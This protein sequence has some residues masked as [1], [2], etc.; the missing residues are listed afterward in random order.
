MQQTGP[1]V[2]G[3][4]GFLTTTSRRVPR[5]LREG[6]ARKVIDQKDDAGGEV[7]VSRAR[8]LGKLTLAPTGLLLAIAAVLLA[9]HLVGGR[10]NAATARAAKSV[11]IATK[12]FQMS[13]ADQKERLT[14]GC[15][16]RSAPLGGGMTT[17][18]PPGADGEGVYPHSYERLGVQRGWH[19]TAVLFDPNPRSTQA[20]DVTLQAVCGPKL[21]HVTPPH[22]TKYVKP[23]QTKKVV[24][25]CPGRRHLFAGGFQRTDFITM[26]GNYVI[27]SQAVSGKSWRVVGHAFG[28]FGG[29]LTAIAYCV[30]SKRPLVTE[31]TAGTTLGTG[32]LGT[33]TTPPCPPGRRMTSGGFSGNGSESVLFTNGMVNPDGTWSASGYGT[34]ASTSFT[35]HGYCLKL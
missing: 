11:T 19:V 1:R 5:R 35:A 4:R 13:R 14:V 7:V 25:T 2:S 29:E 21:G 30:R 26:G 32:Q 27:E 16:G 9:Q 18:P 31:V 17:N 23:G 24:A 12:T 20:R 22:K 34:G 3:F 15:P 33:A 10:A 8:H 28:A 6:N